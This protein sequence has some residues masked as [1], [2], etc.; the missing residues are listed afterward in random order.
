MCE[1]ASN[2]GDLP[3]LCAAEEV[4]GG[5]GA[6]LLEQP[7]TDAMFRPIGGQACGFGFVEDFNPIVDLINDG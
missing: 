6:V 7:V 1:S 3:S 5:A 4:V 2:K